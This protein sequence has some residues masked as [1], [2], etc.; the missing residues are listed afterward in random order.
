MGVGII[1]FIWIYVIQHLSLFQ[2]RDIIDTES[3]PDL[4]N[5][6]ATLLTVSFTFIILTSPSA[7]LVLGWK[8]FGLVWHIFVTHIHDGS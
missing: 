1:I 6:T 8:Y 4:V 3:G 2:R 5:L 7:V